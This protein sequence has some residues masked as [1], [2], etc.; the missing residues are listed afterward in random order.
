MLLREAIEHA[1]EVARTATCEE[2]REEHLQ[3]AGWLKELEY[4]R[5]VMRC[6]L[7]PDEYAKLSWWRKLLIILKYY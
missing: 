6:G 5:G 1:E 3:L 4:R 2:C 7:L